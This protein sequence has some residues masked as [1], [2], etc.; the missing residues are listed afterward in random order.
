M[1][2]GTLLTAGILGRN[3]ATSPAVTILLANVDAFGR[4]DIHNYKLVHTCLLYVSVTIDL[5]Q[6]FAELVDRG[7]VSHCCCATAGCAFTGQR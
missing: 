4:G 7:L 3:S 1:T 6:I 2:E 5:C